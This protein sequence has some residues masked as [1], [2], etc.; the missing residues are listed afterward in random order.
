MS[1]RGKRAQFY[2]IAAV[3]ISAAI[4]SIATIRNS[5]QTVEEQ[6]NFFELSSQVKE[7]SI[8]VLDYGIFSSQDNLTEFSD[9]IAKD[10]QENDPSVEMILIYGNSTNMT[11]KNYANISVEFNDTTI[12]G[13]N[14][15]VENNIV[16]NLGGTRYEK[17]GSAIKKLFI[18]NW[19]QTGIDTSSFGEE[20]NV[21]VNGFKY[22]FELSENKQFFVI[23][24]KTLNGQDY[25]YI[26]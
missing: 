13:A 3:I 8:N 14:E 16:I 7:E 4:I 18:T 1:K 17:Q 21:S 6:N 5:V 24:K 10:L 9:K 19:S 26:K 11:I 25:L 20:V 23:I 2:L 15:D 22:N 12:P